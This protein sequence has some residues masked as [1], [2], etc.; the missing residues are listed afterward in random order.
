METVKKYGYQENPNEA[1]ENEKDD[2]FNYYNDE[3]EYD[4]EADAKQQFEQFY[5]EE[6]NKKWRGTQYQI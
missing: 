1:N 5:K 3:Q 6:N 4:E 2:N